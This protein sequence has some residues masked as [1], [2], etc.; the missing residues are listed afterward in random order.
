M[1]KKI[2]NSDLTTS[3]EDGLKAIGLT[4]EDMKSLEGDLAA[5]PKRDNRICI[6]GHPVTRH[7]VAGALTI[8]K[9][10]KMDCPCKRCRPVVKVSDLRPFLRKTEGSGG[11]HALARGM[12]ALTQKDGKID[13]LEDLVC[14]RC[15][16]KAADLTPAAVTQRGTSAMHATGFDALL[17]GKCRTE[18]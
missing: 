13:W 15:K 10:T 18:V 7:T 4:Q 9:P 16:E 2:D 8:C 5:K 17:C 14:D 12:Y 6:C 11:L 1:P 3:A